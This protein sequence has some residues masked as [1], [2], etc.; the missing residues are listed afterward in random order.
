V[1]QLERLLADSAAPHRRA[2]LLFRLARLQLEVAVLR[3]SA[4]GRPDLSAPV[5]TCRRLL[6]EVPAYSRVAE[7]RLFL[8][9]LER[10]RG[11]PDEARAVLAALDRDPGGDG[12]CEAGLLVGGCWLDAHD[13][14]AA[15]AAFARLLER[16]GCDPA[17]RLEARYQLA[18]TLL[19]DQRAVE[20]ARELRRVALEARGALL[21]RALQDLTLAWTMGAVDPDAGELLLRRAGDARSGARLVLGL[22]QRLLEAGK[23]PGLLAFSSRLLSGRRSAE[24]TRAL[25]VLRVRAVALHGGARQLEDELRAAGPD[26]AAP[27]ITA[28]ILSRARRRSSESHAPEAE[29]LYRRLIA[30]RTA[31]A[32]EAREGLGLLLLRRGAL[33]P[34]AAELEAAARRRGPTYE[35]VYCLERLLEKTPAGQGKQRA[36]RLARLLG[37]AR[38]FLAAHP[39][40][41]RA[42]DVTLALGS[43]LVVAPGQE[44]EAIAL[45]QRF[46][47]RRPAYPRRGRGLELLLT[48]LERA[49]QDERAF[50]LAKRELAGCAA[51][52]CP[53]LR[54]T[55]SAAARRQSQRLAA[56]GR[57]AEAHTWALRAVRVDPSL[58]RTTRRRIL[59]AAATIAARAGRAGQGQRLL[60]KLLR[61]SATPAERREVRGVALRL[62]EAAGKLRE[63][64]QS[65]LEL[66]ESSPTLLAQLRW[67]ETAAE[68]AALDGDGAA[69]RKRIRQLRRL[70]RDERLPARR[71]GPWQ[72]RLG[73]LLE[74]AGG[75][76]YRHYLAQAQVLWRHDGRSA[77]LALVR[78]AELAPTPERARRLFE[79][80]MVQ[81]GPLRRRRAVVVAAARARLGLARLVRTRLTGLGA[82]A[83]LQLLAAQQ[84]PLMELVRLSEPRWAGAGALE[85]ALTLGATAEALRS[86][87]SPR[88][89]GEA[90]RG[91]YRAALEDRVKRLLE[92]RGRLLER[93]ARRAAAADGLD[94]NTLAALRARRGPTTA[95]WTLTGLPVDDGPV[96]P[97]LAR[98]RARQP[99]AARRIATRALEV[100]GRRAD[101]LCAR[102]VARFSSGEVRGALADLEDAL[103]LDPAGRCARDNLAAL[104]VWRG[105][106]ERARALLAAGAAPAAGRVAAE[107]GAR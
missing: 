21:Q 89:L 8:A 77:A 39:D 64:G 13:R 97:V 29:R 35:L 102:G 22:G 105:D 53:A 26:A 36:A 81:A 100:H 10:R 12:A 107:G 40:S 49:G 57:W 50:D 106:N 43:R 18:W 63:A 37:A 24:L 47:D 73:R 38:R 104:S 62:L 92:L 23:L 59:L 42:P 4:S 46:V 68:L 67:T 51:E 74:L 66:A 94:S 54:R 99:R 76:P 25:R 79:Q 19:G 93:L 55:A 32:D 78:A 65:C 27:A 56:G 11:R 90:E 20:A 41:P 30:S 60:E 101:L 28:A 80:A 87:P 6:A 44:G 58:E 15:R 61:E 83:R 103:A 86:S 7:V 33:E 48:A 69:A 45:L 98:I 70:L 9:R 1:R 91:R 14:G 52:S 95:P 85:L 75:E 84:A 31:A 34:A 72:L 2:D 5:F 96:G 71:L 3:E 16:K 17:Q 82:G 88:G